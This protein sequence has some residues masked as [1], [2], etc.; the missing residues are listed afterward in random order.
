MDTTDTKVKTYLLFVSLVSFVANQRSAS[1]VVQVPQTPA[2]VETDAAGEPWLTSPMNF[3]PL[4][5]RG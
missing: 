1:S 3:G 5:L 4:G 2:P